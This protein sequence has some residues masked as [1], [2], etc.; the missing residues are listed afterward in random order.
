MIDLDEFRVV[1]VCDLLSVIPELLILA[2]PKD[3]LVKSFN[4]VG[5]LGVLIPEVHVLIPS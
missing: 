1:L 2:N 4:D 5:K 3:L